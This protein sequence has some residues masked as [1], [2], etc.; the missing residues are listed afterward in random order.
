LLEKAGPTEAEQ[1]GNH[2]A[3]KRTSGPTSTGDGTNTDVI[4]DSGE[5]LFYFCGDSGET[6]RPRDLE[7]TASS[8]PAESC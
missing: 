5:P 1:P 8:I 6:L 2:L 3:A 4:V 7:S